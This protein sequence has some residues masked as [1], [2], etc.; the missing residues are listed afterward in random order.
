M[1]LINL[2]LSE[3]IFEIHFL[4][5]KICVVSLICTG[6]AFQLQN[7]HSFIKTY[8]AIHFRYQLM[9]IPMTFIFKYSLSRDPFM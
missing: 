5:V 1:E 3:A 2:T 8:T 9:K 6:N 4:Q 7:C